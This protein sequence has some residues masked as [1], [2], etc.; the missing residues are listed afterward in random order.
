M[1][2]S[3]PEANVTAAGNGAPTITATAG[4][5]SGQAMG[6]TQVARAVAV[7]P[8]I[9]ELAAGG[10]VRLVA[11]ATDTNGHT[12]GEAVVTWT[13][14]NESRATADAS[15]LVRSVGVSNATIVAAAGGIEAAA[16][17]RVVSRDLPVL[18]AFYDARDGAGWIENEDRLSDRPLGEW[19]G[20][21]MFSGGYL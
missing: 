16:Q 10:T 6:V 9:A 3:G 15:G 4:S 20:V 13:S 5:V 19:H 18:T 1:V 11:E 12:I 21:T 8:A 2:T 7:A 14:T 17:I